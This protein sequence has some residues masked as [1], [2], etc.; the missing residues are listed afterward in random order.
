MWVPRKSLGTS[1]FVIAYERQIKYYDYDVNQESYVI[2]YFSAL[3]SAYLNFH[4]LVI[5]FSVTDSNIFLLSTTF[6]S[7][8]LYIYIN[9]L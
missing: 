2:F 5:N 7:P 9:S 4:P 8:Y 3:S 1:Y 6:T